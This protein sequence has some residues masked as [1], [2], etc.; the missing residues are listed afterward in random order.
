MSQSHRVAFT[1]GDGPESVVVKL[2][3]EDP[4]SR[5]HGRQPRS[6]LPR[7]R[8]LPRPRRA[9]RR[10]RCPA[11]TLAEYDPAEGWFTLV[12]EDIASAVQG[13]QIAGCSVE[14]ARGRDAR[15]G[16]RPRARARR[17]R[18]RRGRLPEPAEPAQPGRH[19]ERAAGRLR[20][21][22]RRP[23]RA[24]AHGDVRPVRPGVRTRGPPSGRRRSVSSTA[25]T[26]STTCCSSDGRVQGRRLADGRL[27]AR[28]CSTPATSSAAR[29]RVED[30]RAHEQRARAAV[31]RRAASPRA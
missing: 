19:A 12:L 8:V 2:A 23:G 10:A 18:A 21:A 25:T 27:G 24:R 9:D 1:A 28:R 17:R 26:G 31:P 6:V 11:V 3:S 20:R 15:A 29:S 7:G 14:L 22:L 4:T 16:A 5:A 13:D 30:R